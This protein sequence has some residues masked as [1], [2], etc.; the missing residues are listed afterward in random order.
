MLILSTKN[1]GCVK[2][3]WANNLSSALQHMTD[4]NRKTI[5]GYSHK[6]L[7]CKNHGYQWVDISA[8]PLERFNCEIVP[9]SF[10]FIISEKNHNLHCSNYF[11]WLHR[12]QITFNSLSK[13][14]EN[15]ACSMPLC[16]CVCVHMNIIYTDITYLLCILKWFVI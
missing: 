7:F 5:L 11:E 12:W 15:V 2:K 9:I 4:R 1:H 16:V 3:Y 14:K 8:F 13:S 10:F 6:F